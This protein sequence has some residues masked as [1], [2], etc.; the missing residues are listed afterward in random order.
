MKHNDR[1]FFNK[2]LQQDD[3]F[4][5]NEIVPLADITGKS[6]RKGL[7]IAVISAGQIVNVVSDGYGHLP[8]EKFFIEAERKLIDADFVYDTRSIN[9]DNRSFAVDYI[10]NDSKFHINVKNGLDK[11]RPMLRFTNCYDGSCKTAGYFGFFRQVCSN[12]LEVCDLQVGFSLKKRGNI[13]EL[14]L[15][16]MDKLITKFMDNE[17]YSLHRKFE[18]LAESP[19]DNIE[20]FVQIT[21]EELELFKFACSEKNPEPSLNARTVIETIERESK[22]L[23]VRPNLWLG[24]NAFN[25]LLHGKLKKTFTEQKKLDGQLF[26]YIL[27]MA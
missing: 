4:V 7:E 22:Q 19:I 10:L 9:R 2:P 21:T 6:V 23:Q 26:E 13:V 25:G 15:P 3:V 17:F 12:G 1:V 5:S 16:E 8:N 20:E 27:E 14:V 24:Y 18:V 11:I